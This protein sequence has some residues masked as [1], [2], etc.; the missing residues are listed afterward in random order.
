MKI[1]CLATRL[2]SVYCS[3]TNISSA[4]AGMGRGWF[5]FFSS[6]S[7]SSVGGFRF[8]CAVLFVS[9]FAPVAS[10][11]SKQA[12]FY[13]FPIL[14]QRAAAYSK[15]MTQLGQELYRL[16]LKKVKENYS[17]K[18]RLSANPGAQAFPLF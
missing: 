10:V 11:L 5:E 16:Y 13:F 6:N 4:S 7:V 1:W 15:A 17:W 14:P 18:P 8:L 12:E 2:P 3:A 9:S